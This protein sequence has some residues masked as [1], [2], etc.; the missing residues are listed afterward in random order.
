[1]TVGE[2]YGERLV[3]AGSLSECKGKGDSRVCDGA[4]TKE[5][6]SS[7]PSVQVCEGGKLTVKAKKKVGTGAPTSGGGNLTVDHI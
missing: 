1:M 2:L 4:V 3:A 6:K 5:L 7:T